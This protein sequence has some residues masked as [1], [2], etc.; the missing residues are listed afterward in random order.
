[1]TGENRAHEPFGFFQ[2]RE[3]NGCAFV[4]FFR[5]GPQAG[6]IRGNNGNLRAREQR[7]HQEQDEA[8]DDDGENIQFR[9]P[10]LFAR[11]QEERGNRWSRSP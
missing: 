10:P 7:F 5:L 8:D 6:A 3:G 1:M 9:H 2:Q 11:A 4:S